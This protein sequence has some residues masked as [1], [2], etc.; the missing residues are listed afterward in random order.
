MRV[1]FWGLVVVAIG[2]AAYSGM[3]AAWQWIAVNN[4][5]DEVISQ[6]GIE[7]VPAAEVKS[8]VMAAITEAG[9]PLRDRDVSVTHGADRAVTVEIV[10]TLPVIVVKGESV[11]AVPLSVQRASASAR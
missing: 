6:A 2:Y 10:W 4:A 9:V 11:L 3:M 7:A 1:F 8:R 5:V